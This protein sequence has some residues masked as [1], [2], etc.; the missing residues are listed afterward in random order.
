MGIVKNWMSGMY[1]KVY[2]DKQKGHIEAV[3]RVRREKD[4]ERKQPK[5]YEGDDER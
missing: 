5:T 2:K 4:I 3:V 1:K